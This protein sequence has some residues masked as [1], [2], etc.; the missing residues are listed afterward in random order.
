MKV[1]QINS[2]LKSGSTGKIAYVINQYLLEHHEEGSIIFGYGDQSDAHGFSLNSYW[3]SH[4]HSFLS[5]KLC[6][7]GRLSCLATLKA[8]KYIR[9]E[10]PDLIH[11]HNIHGH[12]LNYPMLFRFLRKQKIH[13]VWT[14]HDCW[15]FTGKCAHY[16]SVNCMKWKTGCCA[17]PN[18]ATYP[19]TDFDA[20]KKNYLLK[21]K[22]FTSLQKLHIVTVSDWLKSQ[23]Q[24]SFLGS[25]D[26]SRIYNGVDTNLFQPQEKLE[27][28]EKLGIPEDAFVVLGVSSVWK[29]EKGYDTFLAIA[30]T[31]KGVCNFVMVGLTEEKIKTLPDY[32]Y[33]LVRTE[34]QAEL[35]ALYMSSDVLLNPSTEETFGLVAVEAMACGTPVIVSD[36]TACPEVVNDDRVGFVVDME[37]P[38][39]IIAAIQQVKSKGKA[40][41]REACR[42]AAVENFSQTAMLENYYHLYRRICKDEQ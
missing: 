33:G 2:T 20:S 13:V 29:R 10:K 19:E 34:S 31:L 5:R 9:K 1:I 18:L 12:Y 17:C 37:Q 42:N 22:M 30:E 41:Y 40:Y 27:I 39:Q 28:R 7:Q 25:Q 26:I 24:Q 8:I 14:L 32:I 11:L 6:M 38:T 36:K 35:A 23:V 16:T 15:A 21:K 4:L 3:G